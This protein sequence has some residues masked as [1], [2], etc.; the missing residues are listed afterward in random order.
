[1]SRPVTPEDLFQ[2]TGIA[3]PQLSPDGT[4]VLFEVS[5]PDRK[6]NTTRSNIYLLPLSGGEPRQLTRSEK[7]DGS[8]RW[9]P[10]SK[11]I[12]FVS[13]RTGDW[14]N[15][16]NNDLF[17]VSMDSG[18]SRIPLGRNSHPPGH[19]TTNGSPARHPIEATYPKTAP[20][21]TPRSTLF[22]TEG[23]NPVKLSGSLDRRSGSPT[24]SS[25]SENVYFSAV[26]HGTRHIYRVSHNGGDV[27]QVTEGANQISGF[28]LG[29]E[30]LI[31]D[32][33]SE[34]KPNELYSFDL[35][36]GQ[37]KK[38][39]TRN[40]KWLQEVVTRPSEPFQFKTFDDLAVQGW[41]LK[42]TDFEEDKTYPALLSLHGGPHGS[43]GHGFRLS[44]LALAGA[45]YA[46]VYINPSL[47][48]S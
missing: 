19:Q 26:D 38:L 18:E 7:R 4:H 41:V 15:N 9:S 11:E 30:L 43:H 48:Y 46:V 34:L 24:W 33:N 10:D 21:G 37:E 23:G 31:F 2:I 28:S 42:P 39:T 29:N 36:T 40:L 6:S 16:A 8:P 17:A 45:G 13:N 22:H 20:P 25:D 27:H 35:Q 14:D 47:D 3:N 12:A 5:K 44:H 32:R 1:M